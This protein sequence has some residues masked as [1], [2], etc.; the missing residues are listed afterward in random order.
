MDRDHETQREVV[1]LVLKRERELAGL[2]RLLGP[3]AVAA[4]KMLAADG[5][6][7]RCGEVLWASS[8]LW[9]LDELGLLTGA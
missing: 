4:V 7:V 2:E 6:V 1:R 9:R 3:D 8:A 5:V